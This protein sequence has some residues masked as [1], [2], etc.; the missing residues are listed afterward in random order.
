MFNKYYEDELAFLR[1]LGAEFARANPAAAPYLAERGADP[2]V[3]RLL[4]GFAFLTGRLRQKLDDEV[5]E[6]VQAL[7]QLVWPHFLRPIPARTLLQ[8]EPQSASVREPQLIPAGCEV[9]S[10][11]V[12]GTACRFRTC[13]DVRLLPLSVE[14]V[15]AEQP[16]GTA[17]RI[18]VL[19]RLAAGVKP[20]A[21]EVGALR[22]YL[23]GETSTVDTLF[24]QLTRRLRE[25]V[26]QPAGSTDRR[27]VLKPDAVRPCG[28]DDDESLLPYPPH[29]FPGY[30]VL[31]E[32][33]AFR[34]KFHFLELQGIPRPSDLGVTDAFELVFDFERAP[35]SPPRLTADSLRLHCV[36]VV[37][38]FPVQSDPIRVDHQ[39]VDYVIRP[40][41]TNPLHF[42]VFSVDRVQGWMRGTSEA[43]EYPAFYS[44]RHG[45]A[46]G[47]GRG[48]IYFQTRVREAVVGSGV[49]TT[50]SFVTAGEE[51][52]VPPTE[53][54]VADLTCANRGLPARLRVGDV[55]RPTASSPEFARFRN[56][57]PVRPAIP[58]PLGGELHWRLISGLSLN[59]LS[60]ASTEALRAV[61]AVYDFGALKDKT[62]ALEAEHRLE[63]IVAVR[64]TP[65]ERLLRGAP[66]RGLGVKVVLRP[67]RFGGE[68][69]MLVFAGVLR[70]FLA[71]SC[72]LNSFVR[73]EAQA[74]DQKVVYGWDSKSGRLSLV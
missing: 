60:L 62:A 59:Y 5:P 38:L 47:G 22:F 58:P 36:P 57:T 41:T 13:A 66:V 23:H 14:R 51:G 27:I 44:F 39:R 30:R 15:E 31:Q 61:L 17:G 49:D 55:Q 40:A 25:V 34:E 20:D 3:E 7:V 19:L 56:I 35:E 65:E 33:F 18:R 54:V 64:S 32:Y 43:R 9:E 72:S 1:E 24:L 16:A 53:T 45:R 74:A 68:G 42:E 67:D 37:N 69:H 2:D 70:E 8:F 6:V 71:H 73:L 50:V 11:P 52:A 46:T 12:D 10:V 29:A 4:E 63:G 21:F 26:V 28:F 48:S